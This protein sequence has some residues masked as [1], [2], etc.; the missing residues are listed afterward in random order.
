MHIH[1]AKGVLIYILRSALS[2]VRKTLYSKELGLIVKILRNEKK[3]ILNQKNS[4]IKIYF[5]GRNKKQNKK[6]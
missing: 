1:V 2:R 5:F 3:T 6:K 4:Q